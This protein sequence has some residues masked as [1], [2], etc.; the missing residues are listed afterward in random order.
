M[1]TELRF[2]ERSIPAPEYGDNIAKRGKILQYRT[3]YG[4]IG[5]T[6]RFWNKW[7]DV[8]FIEEELPI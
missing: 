2:I 8:P 5:T 4:L 6:S 3:D 7:V 1:A